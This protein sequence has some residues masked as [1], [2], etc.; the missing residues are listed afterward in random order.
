MN[1]P[2]DPLSLSS[3]SD[4][5]DAPAAE[6]R[7]ALE[8]VLAANSPELLTAFT[9]L[10][11]DRALRLLREGS[12]DEIQEESLLIARGVSGSLGQTLRETSLQAF[13]AWSAL[14]EL[15][16]EAGRRSD[17]AAV[18][19]ILLG[20]RGQAIL[21]LLAGEGRAVP[22]SEIRR[23][24]DF[25]EAHLS[26]LLRD[27]EEADLIVRYRPE[28]AREVQ[29]ELGP[30]G[31]EVV[32]RSVLPAWVERFLAAL[33]GMAEGASIQADALAKELQESGTPS[34]LVA[35]RLAEALAR[36]QTA[37]QSY[38][39]YRSMEV[40]EEAAV[41]GAEE[42]AAAARFTEEVEQS[43]AHFATIRAWQAGRPPLAGFSAAA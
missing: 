1:L 21:E 29:V 22:R 7:P 17:R 28:G 42:S 34:G 30:V 24:L 13:G 25:A 16:A 8:R 20:N 27:L 41:Y 3:F 33:S 26:H 32:S 14:Q 36:L 12:R 23:R 9:D 37:R 18:P 15:L 31:Q 2:S 6:I 43:D 5:D 35:K 11:L 19:S 4:L 40:H 38:P 10:L 39:L